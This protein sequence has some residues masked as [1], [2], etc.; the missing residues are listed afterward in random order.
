LNRGIIVKSAGDGWISA[1]TSKLQMVRA[2]VDLVR[3]NLQLIRTKMG[4][5][6]AKMGLVRAKMGLVRAKVDMVR[7]SCIYYERSEAKNV[8]RKTTIHLT[9]FPIPR[10]HISEH[11]QNTRGTER[12]GKQVESESIHQIVRVFPP[13]NPF[14]LQAVRNTT[15]VNPAPC[16]AKKPSRTYPLTLTNTVARTPS[17]PPAPHSS[18]RVRDSHIAQIYR[19]GIDNWEP[20]LSL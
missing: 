4:L 8:R 9:V 1:S 12:A 16:I 14:K 15:C 7:G 13:Y 19:V 18:L 2:K 17:Y 20:R 6:R 10:S 5:I 3:T 11:H